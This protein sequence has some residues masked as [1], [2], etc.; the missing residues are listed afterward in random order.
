MLEYEPSVAFRW[1]RNPGYYDTK[2]PYL[3]GYDQPILP[4]YSTQLAQF[5]SKNIWDFRPS[6][7]DLGPTLQ[8]LTASGLKAYE[9]P[10]GISHTHMY[11]PGRPGAIFRDVRMRRAASMS[12][13]RV[14]LAETLGEKEK[15]TSQGL[16]P[17]IVINNNI[18]AGYPDF[19]LDPFGKEMG[20]AAQWFKFNQ[21]EAKK[22]ISAAGYP[23]GLRVVA[24]VSSRSHGSGPH[25]EIVHQML[26]EVGIRVQHETVDYNTVYLPKILQTRGDWD[27]D[28]TY[29]GGGT[30]FSPATGLQRVW[31]WDG[32]TTRV[33]CFGELCDNEHRAIGDAI[34]KALKE[35]D[36]EKY[37]SQIYEL[38]RMMGRYQGAIITDF[39]TRPIDLVWPWVQNWGAFAGVRTSSAAATTDGVQFPYRHL[40]ID[41]SKMG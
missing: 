2:L 40:W 25:A 3:D 4:E 32:G 7:A 35:I 29:S 41:K 26:N 27:G 33:S 6:A 22:L 30:G 14:L 24:K 18:T 15:L 21:A 12:I 17:D 37:R 31:H 1:R 10:M 9:G 23:N 20:D 34:E 39:Q 11:F 8:A 13:D 5:R 28:L 19:W 36:V 38:Q 16:P